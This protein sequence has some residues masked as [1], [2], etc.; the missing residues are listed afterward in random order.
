M[1]ENMHIGLALERISRIGSD[2]GS[3]DYHAEDVKNRA[4]ELDESATVED[5][6]DLIM[7][8]CNAVDMA[9]ISAWEESMGEDL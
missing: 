6:C 7:G 4:A 3:T 9:E 2:F 8:L 5:L 1:R